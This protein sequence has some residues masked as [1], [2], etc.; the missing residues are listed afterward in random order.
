MTTLQLLISTIDEGIK[1][2]G[3]LVLAP[4][5]GVSYVISWQI[6]GSMTIA[7]CQQELLMRP[8][9]KVVTMRGRGLSR[10][11]NNAIAHASADVCLIC[12]DDCSYTA[13][14]LREIVHR[15]DADPDLDIATFM[16]AGNVPVP[17][18]YPQEE[19]VLGPKMPRHYYPSSFEIAFRTSSISGKIKFNE[20]FGLGSDM[21]W[22]GEE[23]L[24]L[25]DAI[26]AGLKCVFYPIV[27]VTTS[28]PTTSTTRC[29]LPQVLMARGAYMRTVYPLTC[30]LR[31]VKI[32]FELKRAADQ[33][34]WHSL[35]HML[36]G[37]SYYHKI[38]SRNHKRECSAK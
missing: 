18:A 35:H 6:T 22:C 37:I 15:F 21:L 9:V 32:A 33:P 36:K 20:N 26:K 31:A 19:T 28:K 38:K 13:G 17:K 10:N 5:E 30:R 16:R 12:D 24:F 11:R 4:I 3:D 25:H 1:L 14:Q 2:I 29:G 27:V 7:D 8:D 34:V 23:E